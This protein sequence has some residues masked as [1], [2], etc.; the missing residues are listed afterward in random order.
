MAARASSRLTGS[1]RYNVANVKTDDR[2][3]PPMINDAGEQIFLNNDFRYTKLNPALGLVWNPA[4]TIGNHG[5]SRRATAR[6]H[7]S[8]L[9]A[10]IRRI[11]ACCRTR[12]K[13]IRISSRW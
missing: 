3:D 10:R 5:E 8:S 7:R 1:L 2:L 4:P 9:P 12:C 6:H 13:R 11:P